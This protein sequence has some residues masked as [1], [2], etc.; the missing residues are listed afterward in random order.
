MN[1]Q[2]DAVFQADPEALKKRQFKDGLEAIA[3]KA[4][5]VVQALS[6]PAE[7]AVKFGA[8]VIGDVAQGVGAA[9]KD[10]IVSQAPGYVPPVATPAAAQTQQA[11]PPPQVQQQATTTQQQQQ[12]A[13]ASQVQTTYTPGV[14]LSPE[15][16]K[17]QVKALDAKEEAALAQNA[18]EAEFN[19]NQAL[20]IQQK[21]ADLAKQQELDAAKAQAIKEDTD[22]EQGK[23]LAA[24]EDA[25]N[26][27]VDP[28]REK[29][30]YGVGGRI[31]AAIVQGLGAW[32]AAM[33]RTPNYAMQILKD[34]TD[35]DIRAQEHDIATK[36]DA[37][38]MRG[39]TLQMFR[40]KLGDHEVAARANKSFLLDQALGKIDELTATS[41]NESLLARADGLRAGIMQEKANLAAANYAQ[42][43]GRTVR[44]EVKGPAQGPSVSDQVKL[45]GLKVDVPQKDPKTGKDAGT[46]T[47][48]ARTEKDAEKIRD[49]L[50]VRD[51]L[52]K[53]LAKFGS[54]IDEHWQ[55]VPG[56][57]GKKLV[58]AMGKRLF[59]K[60]AVLHNLGA[61]SGPDLGLA[62]AQFGD[63]TSIWQ[64]DGQTHK[65]IDQ[66]SSEIDN[67][68]DAEMRGRG[69]YR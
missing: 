37:V 41:K 46:K 44:Q 15:I 24:I 36:K 4:V 32:G 69:M 38:T 3:Q 39:N 48:M 55:S 42:A 58:E 19:R 56:T 12:P 17:A 16:E 65:L 59:T 27:K 9:A 25:K 21:N 7:T 49:A 10:Y 52:K 20:V 66:F 29:N 61:L 28:D 23:Y 60:F 45:E 50:V 30:K 26:A 43:Q 5:P 6:H 1:D 63:P 57:T 40:Q 47:Y 8:G 64:R 31:L 13:Q 33:G 14:K 68:V 18:V 51:D 34:A 22:K 67:K 11:A 53:D 54:L 2:I 35:A 62:E